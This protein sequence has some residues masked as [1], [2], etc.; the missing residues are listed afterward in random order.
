MVTAAVKEL[1]YDARH[2]RNL[3][4]SKSITRPKEETRQKVQITSKVIEAANSI[5]NYSIGGRLLGVMTGDEVLESMDEQRALATGQLTTFYFLQ[6]I[7][8]KVTGDR[9]VRETLTE[10]QLENA[11]KKAAAKAA[12]IQ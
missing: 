9:V 4:I 8:V 12:K 5:Y 2:I 11:L 3:A 7:S 10:R 1:I 6:V